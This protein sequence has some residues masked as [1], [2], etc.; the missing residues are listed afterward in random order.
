MWHAYPYTDAH[1]LNL[2]W[3]I[4]QIKKLENTM[5][6]FVS[7]ASIKYADPILWDITSQY[8]QNTVVIDPQTGNGYLSTKAVPYGI[9]I[10]NTDY[11]TP[12][13]NYSAEINRLEGMINDEIHDR[14]DADIALQGQID[15]LHTDIAAIHTIDVNVLS[16]GCDPTGTSDCAGHINT[17]L[18]DHDN[19]TLYFP[20]GTYRFES[21]VVLTG[22][23]HVNIVGQD[24]FTTIFVYADTDYL[25][26]EIYIENMH[27]LTNRSKTFKNFTVT[28]ATGGVFKFQC[29]NQRVIQNVYFKGCGYGFEVKGSD[30]LYINNILQSGSL[31]NE[32]KYDEI[33]GY[34]LYNFGTVIDGWSY[35]S[36]DTPAQASP[37]FTME[38][39]VNSYISH[40]YTHGRIEGIA[41]D[42]VGRG[43]G[44]FFDDVI[45]VV[46]TWGIT[47]HADSD[48][49]VPSCIEVSNFSIDQ[50]MEGGILANLFWFML[51]NFS[52]V[53]GT[54]RNNTQAAI[55]IPSG[56]QDIWIRD[57]IIYNWNNSAINM[58]S[59]DRVEIT[60]VNIHGII[61]TG[62]GAYAYVNMSQTVDNPKLSNNNFDGAIAVPTYVGVDATGN[63]ID[64]LYQDGMLVGT[65]TA[66]VDT[67]LLNI[68][69]PAE[70]YD[71]CTMLEY[72]FSINTD[73]NCTAVVDVGGYPNSL[74]FIANDKID[75]KVTQMKNSEDDTWYG[76]GTFISNNGTGTFT[77]NVLGGYTPH[78]TF[79]ITPVANLTYL[80][81]NVNV[82]VVK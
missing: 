66:G 2:D 60:G 17:Y 19:I 24:E 56:A 41:F 48:G 43:E 52:I 3:I 79:N 10:T 34:Y 27:A 49:N 71:H 15:D 82:K 72:Q 68:A 11:W 28:A 45:L 31:V 22:L 36:N 23:D 65:A 81:S 9:S 61:D 58:D 64:L 50:P 21:P 37:W 69:L 80:V 74:S 73:A 1:E 38:G 78:L 40:V 14:E 39:M 57:G 51:N 75:V 33:T 62:L 5:E 70:V 77:G 44:L 54:Q 35:E 29:V 47:C 18:S 12:I 13:F 63:L 25:F 42:L 53:N 30:G 55:I 26:K 59:S 32:W 7:Y 16:I 6:T 4:R 46:P 76:T 20:N 8:E 67:N